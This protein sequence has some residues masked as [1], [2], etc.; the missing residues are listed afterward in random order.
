MLLLDLLEKKRSHFIRLV[1]Y[2][3]TFL[4]PLFVGLSRLY[5]GAHSLNQI[6][7][8]WQFGMWTALMAHYT[9]RDAIINH[10]HKLLAQPC[11]FKPKDYIIFA[12]IASLLM[13]VAFFVLLHLYLE[14]T[15]T[16][17]PPD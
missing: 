3:L 4:F 16:F 12:V 7:L 13:A 11:C 10:V 15:Y 1:A 17:T 9:F 6:F 5:L 14:V 2:S 8:G